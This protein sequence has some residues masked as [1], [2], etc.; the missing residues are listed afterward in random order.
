MICRKEICKDRRAK[1]K[2]ITSHP[3]FGFFIITLLMLFVQFLRLIGVPISNT[4]LRAFGITMIYIIVALGFSVLLGYAGLASLGTAGFVGV[5][6]YILGYF[7]ANLGWSIFPIIIV[8]IFGAIVIGAIV[9]FIS[10]RIEGMYLAII[11][12]GLSEILNEVFKNATS[13]TNGTNGLGLDSKIVIFKN[14]VVVPHNTIFIFLALIMFVMMILTLNIIKS[15]TGRAL[16]AMRNST[17]AAQAM[18]VSIFKYRLMA[19]IVSTVYA[20]L[21]GIIYMSYISFSIP[22]TWSL[23]FS[24]NILAA[25]IVGGSQSIYG[26]VLGTFMIFGLNLAVFQ[27]ID[28]LVNNP[29]ISIVFNGVLIVLVIMFYPGGLIRLVQTLYYKS[30]KGLLELHKKWRAYRYGADD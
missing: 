5:G 13:I 20:M 14:L 10:L 30:K 8:T 9:G 26:I 25:V 29:A 23:A 2:S 27:Q 22:T 28:F 17:S 24:L 11:T 4:L 12:L 6:T 18:G 7:T 19:F 16:L 15:P 21:G 3:Y 1:I